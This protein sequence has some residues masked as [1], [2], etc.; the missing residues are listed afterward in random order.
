MQFENNIMSLFSELFKT[1]LMR[2]NKDAP[3]KN[4]IIFK[5]NGLVDLSAIPRAAN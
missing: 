2:R 5:R 1:Q 4:K 3:V